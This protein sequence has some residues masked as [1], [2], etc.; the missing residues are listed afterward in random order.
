MKTTEDWL[1]DAERRPAWA[2]LKSSVI[3]VAIV[4]VCVA[5]VGLATTG[6]VF[7]QGAAARRTVGSKT[8]VRVFSADNK[9][10]QIAFFHDSCETVNRQLRVVENN[11]ERLRA[12]EHAARYATDPIARQQ[13]I[14]GLTADQQDVTGAQNALAATT[15]DY[16][17]RSA[18]S[19]AS[20]FK[21]GGLPSRINLPVS[22]EPGFSVDCG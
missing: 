2:L 19:T 22:P 13:A 10:A 3:L 7:F 15:A 12:D 14:D 6:S 17:S 20:V 16:N 9:I 5:L 11:R 21:D 1:R 4:L 18:Q 8:D